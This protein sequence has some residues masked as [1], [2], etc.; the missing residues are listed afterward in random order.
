MIKKIL[1]AL[2]EPVSDTLI[3]LGADAMLKKFFKDA[4]EKTAETAGGKVV[5]RT[6]KKVFEDQRAELLED[7]RIMSAEDP[8]SVDNLIR[9]H[10]ESI[11]NKP[12]PEYRFAS[13]LCKIEKTENKGR[14]LTLKYLNDLDDEIFW[15][16]LYLLE[17]DIVLQWLELARRSGGRIT[18]KTI[19]WLEKRVATPIADVIVRGV[20]KVGDE[21]PSMEE[22][23]NWA[24][25]LPGSGVP[26]K[27]RGAPQASRVGVR[28]GVDDSS[29]YYD[30][31][32]LPPGHEPIEHEPEKK[33]SPSTFR[34]IVGALWN[35]TNWLL[36]WSLRVIL[37]SLILIPLAGIWQPKAMMILVPIFLVAM[38]YVLTET[39]LIT[40]LLG[41]ITPIYRWLL[42]IIGI[43]LTAGAYVLIVPVRNDWNLASFLV[44]VFL[45]YCCFLLARRGLWFRRS[46]LAVIALGTLFLFLGGLNAGW[47]AMKAIGNGLSETSLAAQQKPSPAP[48]TP[49]PAPAPPPQAKPAAPT[50]TMATTP[51]TASQATIPAT[52]ESFPFRATFEA[53]PTQITSVRDGYLEMLFRG[54]QRKG[55]QVICS[56]HAKNNGPKETPLIF[57]GALEVR[58]DNGV[59]YFVSEGEFGDKRCFVKSIPQ[60]AVLQRIDPGEEVS[61][62]FIVDGYEEGS[63]TL[64]ATISY[65]FPGG[66]QTKAHFRIPIEEEK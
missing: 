35:S 28:A 55:S 3:F 64:G 10:K 2:W 49:P 58:S 19:E 7:F 27:K 20:E 59:G 61:F 57:T 26:K 16:M 36:R 37:A 45:A 1:K 51:T 41:L 24:E 15:Q 22:T 4:A 5:E 66:H 39:P 48:V 50:P 8:K 25:K 29:M 52:Q 63:K 31:M 38:I 23:A 65:F 13:L 53:V 9:R 21:L 18:K 62:S 56:G 14:R 33:N 60:P 17:H 40:I 46:L 54:C 32:G 11:E 6:A 30:F 42:P 43:M 44:L 34:R 12:I 47:K